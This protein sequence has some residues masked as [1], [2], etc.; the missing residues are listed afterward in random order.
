MGIGAALAP[1]LI[2]WLGVE[3]ALIVDRRRSCPSSS[4]LSVRT[5]ARIDAA[6]AAPEADEL[7][8]LG[9]VPIFAPLPGGSLEHLAARLVP[10][11]VDAG[12]VDR[13]RGRRGRPLLHRR[14]G[15]ASRSRRTAATISELAAG[16]LLRRDRA[17]SRRRAYGDGDGAHGRRPLRARP[18]GL[19][20]RGDGASAERGGRRD[21][22]ERAPR[23]PGRDRLPRPRESAETPC[24][25]HRF[26]LATSA[27]A[28]QRSIP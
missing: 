19:P 10:L 1:A 23:R 2:S 3:D 20:R 16:R 26:E 4:L 25:R 6:A 24:A 27:S 28:G 7:R 15:R 21:G 8:I 9:S 17:S 18:R 14:R 12:T 22:D 5:V 11:R 13:P